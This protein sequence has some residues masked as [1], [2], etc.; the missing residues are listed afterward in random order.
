M[1]DPAAAEFPPADRDA[2]L[3]LVAGV[4]KGATFERRL[5]SKTYDGIAIEPLYGRDETARPII[6]RTPGAPWQVLSRIE[7]PDPVAANAQ[8]LL[9]LENGASGLSLVFAGSIGAFG[10]GLDARA[11]AVVSLLRDIHLDAGI[12][13]DLE[14]DGQPENIASAV[15]AAVAA[16][17]TAPGAVDIRFGFDP[18]GIIATGGHAPSWSADHQRV[19]RQIRALAGQGYRG[20]FAMADGRVI[21][22]GGGSEAQ[23]LAF[24]IATAL[25][26]LRALEA[27]GAPLAEA[28]RMIYFRLAADA[29]QFLTMAKFRALRALWARVEQACGLSP[30]PA[31]VAA[32]TA[33]RMMT[34]R[35]PF[36]N[37]LR[38]TMAVVA[39]GLGG[40]DAITVLPHTAAIGLPDGLAR[41]IARNT[42]LI[43]LEE[44][45]LAKVADPAAG[46]GGFESLT[47]ALC[48][49][50]WSLF[51]EIEKAGGIDRALTQG[52]V[53]AKVAA[54]RAEREKAVAR[55]KDALTGTSEFPDI[56]ETPAVVLEPAPAVPRPASG[57]AL[58]PHRLAEPFEALRDA[59]D[60][61]VAAGAPPRVF[62]ANLGTPA[63]FT[64]RTA[65]AKNF[66][67]AGGI[68]AV[69]NDG[70]ASLDDMVAAFKASSAALACLCSS[71]K[72]YAL[73]AEAA[74]KA[75]HDA[76]AKHIYLAGRPGEREAALVAAGI[77]SFIFVGTDVLAML[78]AAHA[79]LGIPQAAPGA[80]DSDE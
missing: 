80:S 19:A 25:A 24:V 28:R 53:Q 52:L 35:D 13:L 1:S 75:L 36:V 62:L 2:W 69:T 50:A 60:R 67:E 72:V 71:D 49:A 47:R 27:G 30:R 37:M 10:F 14:A 79:V 34:K 26:Y 3:K 39:A 41:R 56:A 40:A 43:L 15:T 33:W 8:A 9:E 78:K 45:N 23:E 42:Q 73:E 59:A 48:D 64:A 61:A 76:G 38:T 57:T 32:Q 12:A 31:F 46:S 5:V 22:N 65:Y 68:A 54:V 4:L 21:H 29:D 44:S 16:R 7:H 55:R 20:P 77:G 66:F 6:G 63:D 70:F 18:I 58:P 17:G 74:A 51:Q 11:T